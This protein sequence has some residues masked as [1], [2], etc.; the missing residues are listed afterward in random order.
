MRLCLFCLVLV[1]SAAASERL[2]LKLWPN[3]APEPPGFQARPETDDTKKGGVRRV[4]NVSVPAITLYAPDRPNGAAVLVCPGGG[5]NILALEHEGS[6]VCEWLNTL[7]ITGVLVKN[8]VPKR[9]Q[10]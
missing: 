7:G 9:G 8:R 4:G 6:E 5:Y 2:T 3:G 10:A 1:I